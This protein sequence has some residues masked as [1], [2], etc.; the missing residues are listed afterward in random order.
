MYGQELSDETL[1]ALMS[2][3]T[4]EVIQKSN[5]ANKIFNEN[6][7]KL[8]AERKEIVKKIN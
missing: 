6:L 3:V 4:E 1:A 8:I 7:L 2:E 5:N